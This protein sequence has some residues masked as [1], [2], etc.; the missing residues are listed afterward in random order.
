MLFQSIN[1][2]FQMYL[3]IHNLRP[4]FL[5]VAMTLALSAPIATSQAALKD[6]VED[7]FE[8]LDADEI[9]NI[10][11]VIPTSG[12]PSGYLVI[13]AKEDVIA[14]GIEIY[15]EGYR[16]GDTTFNGCI[17]AK[18]DVD[19]VGPGDEGTCKGE[20]DSGKRFKLRNYA[21]NNHID[22]Q[23][24]VST[25]GQVDPLLYN[26]Y[27]KVTN[28]G[29]TPAT[30]FEI[31]LGTGIGESFQRSDDV[32]GISLKTYQLTDDDQ[33]WIGKYPGGLFGGSPAEGLPFF[34][35]ESAYY[36]AEQDGDFL[37]T[38]AVPSQ[39]Y[40]VFGLWQTLADVPGAWLYDN[41]GRPWTDGKLQAYD[42]GGTWYVYKKVW[43][44]DN[45]ALALEDFTDAN[46]Q[47]PIEW[48]QLPDELN[49]LLNP[50][51]D[52]GELTEWMNAEA[53][54]TG[55]DSAIRIQE[56]VDALIEVLSLEREELAQ[57][58]LDAWTAQPVTV[59][60]SV[61]PD[62]A[63]PSSDEAADWPLV[64]TWYQDLGEEGLYVLE[65][66]YAADQ[67]FAGLTEVLDDGTGRTVVT[68]DDMATV[69]KDNTGAQ[70]D[71]FGIP[72]YFED[73]IEDLSNV[74]TAV[75]ISVEPD[76]ALAGDKTMTLRITLV[77]TGDQVQPPED[78]GDE[79]D[80]GDDESSSDDDNGGCTVGGS[81]SA[82]DPT[83]PLLVL[84]G[85][86]GLGLR[87]RMSA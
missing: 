34:T 35:T 2:E 82:L 52:V 3:L 60:Y 83:L 74:N 11:P 84:A 49:P 32:D 59:K 51:A 85:L 77:D 33:T 15:D 1:M 12:D 5:T 53:G 44:T 20:V 54:L 66:A 38:T 42:D 80:S 13:D 4:R 25:V 68:A 26:V 86:A 6:I 21:I 37:A 76:A 9:T 45:I 17:M 14:P 62:V 78:G 7:N 22:I 67:A 56:V 55:T 47:D 29:G 63:E 31:E 46:N 87:R 72:G 39:Y 8:I 75:A 79:G 81:G 73:V 58:T 18:K 65:P 43:A 30:G 48:A 10:Y 24:T 64:A 23:F 57:E 41:D 27:A 19:L 50:Y 61:D 40:D 71:F 70:T 16:Q 28:D 69:V 36:I